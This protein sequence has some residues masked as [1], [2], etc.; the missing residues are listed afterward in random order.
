MFDRK[1]ILSEVHTV[2]IHRCGDIRM[3]VH[4]EQCTGTVGDPG[5][6]QRMFVDIPARTIFVP[7][8]KELHPDSERLLHRL[9]RPNAQEILI[10]DQAEPVDVTLP[11]YCSAP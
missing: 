7:V 11:G 6:L 5:E 8:L 3:I 9:G 10:D 1:V 2:R 4:D